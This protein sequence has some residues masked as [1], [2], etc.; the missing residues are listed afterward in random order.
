[1]EPQPPVFPGFLRDLSPEAVSRLGEQ[2]LREH[3]LAQA[4]AAH[5]RHAPLTFEKLPQL[6]SDPDCVR[7]PVRL[8]FDLGPM[9][10]HQFAEPAP[11]PQ[12]PAGPMRVLY[13]R[14]A[15]RDKPDL[16]P[17]AVAYLI[18]VINYGELI[19]D[20]HALLYGATLLGLGEEEYYQQLCAM[21]DACGVAST[22]T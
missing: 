20:E 15:L 17:L 10:P 7:H 2:G 5:G 8:V 4:R 13:L 9:A 12:E 21:A 18:P 19:K 3:L 11:D 6:L 22:L 1:M 14:P 16:V